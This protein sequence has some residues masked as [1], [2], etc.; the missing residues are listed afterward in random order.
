MAGKLTQER[1]AAKLNLAGWDLSR[2]SLAQIEIQIRGVSDRELLFLAKVLK[3]R[4]NDLY[5][6][7]N[8]K[9]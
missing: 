2:A 8:P 3:V 6:S 1:M 4:P 7:F 5:S 9:R